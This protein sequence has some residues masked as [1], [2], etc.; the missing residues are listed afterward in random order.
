[1]TFLI[2]SSPQHLPL[3]NKKKQR[4]ETEEQEELRRLRESKGLSIAVDVA[5]ER[6]RNFHAACR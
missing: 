2:F 6:E 4:R 5:D 1:M 3:P